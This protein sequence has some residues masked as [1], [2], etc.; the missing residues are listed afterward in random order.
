MSE[1][2]GASKRNRALDFFRFVFA[3]TVVC[4]HTVLFDKWSLSTYMGGVEFFLIVT[5]Y[6]LMKKLDTVDVEQFSY[7]QFIW[8]K[9]KGFYP[10]FVVSTLVGFTV[11]MF[12]GGGVITPYTF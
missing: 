2:I 1:I 8:H 3:M 9:L 4:H 5:G 10:A 7:G 12:W 11:R 6:L